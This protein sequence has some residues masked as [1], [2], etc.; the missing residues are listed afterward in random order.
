MD[1]DINFVI[2]VRNGSQRVPDKNFRP[3]FKGKSLLEIKVGQL[4]EDVSRKFITIN[5][6]PG[7]AQDIASKY[8][9]NFINRS[10]ALT[11]SE[12]RPDDVWVD[13]ASNYDSES[14]MAYVLCNN[15]FFNAFSS[16]ISE[17]ECLVK[18]GEYSGL[19]SIS[20]VQKHLLDFDGNPLGFGFGKD[21]L[22]SENLNYLKEINGGIQIGKISD[23]LHSRSLF[24]LHPFFLDFGCQSFEIDSLVEFEN[25]KKIFSI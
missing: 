19:S 1:L 2:P 16:A 23:I 6:D 9:V 12:A 21:W 15:P 14:H 13:V 20:I 18:S 4:L 5:G 25:A 24:G 8:G 7:M 11:N 22:P 17:Y 3:F 10:K